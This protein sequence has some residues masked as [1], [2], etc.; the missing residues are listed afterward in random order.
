MARASLLALCV[1]VLLGVGAASLAAAVSPPVIAPGKKVF[2]WHEKD[3]P[4]AG[5][6]ELLDM[7]V[8]GVP[9][10]SSVSID[11]RKG[12]SLHARLAV[13][14]TNTLKAQLRLGSVLVGEVT[15]PGAVGYYVEFKV[16]RGGIEAGDRL[17]LPPTGRRV[18]HPCENGPP[19]PPSHLALTGSPQ[20]LT[21]SEPKGAAVSYTVSYDGKLLGSVSGTSFKA[22]CG[23]TGSSFSVAAHSVLG[24]VSDPSSPL[25]VSTHSCP[26]LTQPTG[27]TVSKPST[28]SLTLK[29]S[30]FSDADVLGYHLYLF[31]GNVPKEVGSTTGR[32]KSAYTF[33]HLPCGTSSELGVAAYDR[34][35]QSPRA[36]LVAK[37]VSCVP[38]RPGVSS[39]SGN[40]F[41]A[42]WSPSIG[43][44]GYY[45][46]LTA[47][48]KKV[49]RWHTASATPPAKA[50]TSLDI[51]RK[52]K[53][54]VAYSVSV[55]SWDH[56]GDQQ[57]PLGPTESSKSPVRRFTPRCG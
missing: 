56:P 13:G 34:T 40:G 54:G 5:Y 45:V 10:G 50:P 2:T 9:A 12:C 41:T 42:A 46:Y 39:V 27:L 25:K 30:A 24:Y 17:C 57:H 44:L 51:K 26:P 19:P 47:K 6:V 28:K 55:A 31:P 20:T 52:L 16:S 48:G 7:K 32:T 22:G 8:S 35:A 37:T 15:K 38:A 14:K 11:C 23:Y 49:G 29:W 53:C 3:P 18:P 1:V 36:A 4:G 43:A 33:R 21:W